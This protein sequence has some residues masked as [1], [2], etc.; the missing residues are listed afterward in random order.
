MSSG[1]GGGRQLS[2]V[3][4][5]QFLTD[6]LWGHDCSSARL[7]GDGVAWRV[8]IGAGRSYD[9][10]LPFPGRPLGT[11]T[12]PSGCAQPSPRTGGR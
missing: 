6:G 5:L 12:L 4:P 1:G 2:E 7:A 11:A 10:V 8:A 3:L 9:L